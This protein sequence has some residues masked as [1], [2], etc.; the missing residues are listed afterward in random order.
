MLGFCR[1][2]EGAEYSI[3]LHLLAYIIVSSVIKFVSCCFNLC[4]AVNY[5]IERLYR[6]ILLLWWFLVFVV[7]ILLAKNYLYHHQV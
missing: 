4:L 7:L 1:E 2:A 3:T 5:I 6:L